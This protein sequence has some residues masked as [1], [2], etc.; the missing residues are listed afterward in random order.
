MGEI[1]FLSDEIVDLFDDQ[2][3][4][5]IDDKL[6]KVEFH[7][8]A[9]TDDSEYRSRE[10]DSYDLSITTDLTRIDDSSKSKLEEYINSNFRV[11]C[12]SGKY[13]DIELSGML[14][15]LETHRDNDER[16]EW[17]TFHGYVWIYIS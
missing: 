3:L 13:P 5:L 9:E 4:A 2:K 17:A 15:E 12:S 11:Y 10:I 14:E 6:L 8:F 7:I 16:T 1:T